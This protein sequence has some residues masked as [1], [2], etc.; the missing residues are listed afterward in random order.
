MSVVG[1]KNDRGQLKSRQVIP[2]IPTPAFPGHP[3]GTAFSYPK[4]GRGSILIAAQ[5]TRC[6]FGRTETKGF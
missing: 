6:V 5:V 2:D 1:I 3:L 4:R